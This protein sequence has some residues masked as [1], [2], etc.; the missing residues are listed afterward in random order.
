MLG[1]AVPSFLL[2]TLLIF[3]LSVYFRILPNSGDFV[4]LNV[5]PTRN[6]GQ[7]IFPAFTLGF[8][9]AAS[10]MRID[11]LRHARS[12]RA[13]ITCAPPAAK[14]IAL[15]VRRATACAAAMP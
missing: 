3:V 7:M 1:L 6:L 9:F 15:R 10:V 4:A 12:A 11:P 13:R 8:S 2:G 5:D 14:G